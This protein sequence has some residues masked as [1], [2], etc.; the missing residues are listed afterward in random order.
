MK[1]EAHL[2]PTGRTTQPSKLDIHSLQILL[3]CLTSHQVS[4]KLDNLARHTLVL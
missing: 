3:N 4:F 2:S 1:Q